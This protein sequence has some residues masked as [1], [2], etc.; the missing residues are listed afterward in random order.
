MKQMTESPVFEKGYPSYEAVNGKSA[1]K[2]EA[3]QQLMV[4]L[5]EE[6]GELVQACSKILRRE[7]KDLDNPKSEY[8]KNL[9]EEVGDVYCMIEILH[10]WDII[11]WDQL[12]KRSKIKKEKL[13]KWSDLV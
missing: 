5:S 10:E 2:L 8:L 7:C 3:K 12:E 1:M 13:K 4:L 6:C 9:I 11:S